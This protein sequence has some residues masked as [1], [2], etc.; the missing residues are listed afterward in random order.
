MHP[1]EFN[2]YFILS[3]ILFVVEDLECAYVKQ[4]DI[5]DNSKASTVLYSIFNT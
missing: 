3:A 2:H 1:R 4:N 5:T